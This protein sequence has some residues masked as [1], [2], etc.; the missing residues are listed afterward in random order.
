MPT[1]QAHSE[2]WPL[3]YAGVIGLLSQALMPEYIVIFMCSLLGAGIGLA[4]RES[5][6]LATKR[7]PMYIFLANAA[8]V[9][10]TSLV[11]CASLIVV[12]GSDRLTKIVGIFNFGA[13]CALAFLAGI[14]LMIYRE[15]LLKRLGIHI[16]GV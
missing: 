3:I 9:L 11:V 5:P 6:N 4:F 7:H 1:T 14:G 2:G 12:I 13:M 16:D 15:R 10:V 8:Y